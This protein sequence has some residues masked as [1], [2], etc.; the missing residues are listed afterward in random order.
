MWSVGRPRGSFNRWKYDEV[1]RPAT[2]SSGNV[3]RQ[4]AGSRDTGYRDAPSWDAGSRDD[5]AGKSPSN[6]SHY[7]RWRQPQKLVRTYTTTPPPT[8]GRRVEQDAKHDVDW[9]YDTL[10]FYLR[11]SIKL[12]LTA[13]L[14]ISSGFC[15]CDQ[16]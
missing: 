8:P 13:C 7:H 12:R 2:P 16:A 1:Y 10:S 15:K 5:H 4:S 11:V 3:A 9:A 14:C 6:D